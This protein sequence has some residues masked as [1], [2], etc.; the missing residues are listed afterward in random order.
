MFDWTMY[1][2]LILEEMDVGNNQKDI[3]KKMVTLFLVLFL[4]FSTELTA[5]EFNKSKDL[6]FFS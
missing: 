6:S 2:I 3:N 1:L 4:F 5:N